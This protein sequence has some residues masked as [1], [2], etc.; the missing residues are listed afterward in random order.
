MICHQW[1][2]AI[3]SVYG[4]GNRLLIA[5]LVIG[6]GLVYG[7]RPDA[8]E[9]QPQLGAT[10]LGTHSDGGGE[11]CFKVT[12]D[13]AAARGF[14]L[15][16]GAEVRM[17]ADCNFRVPSDW[18]ILT[19]SEIDFIIDLGRPVERCRRSQTTYQGA[20]VA[21][22]T[23]CTV[24]IREQSLG[25]RNDRLGFS[26]AGTFFGEGCSSG[27][28]ETASLPSIGWSAQAGSCNEAPPS[29]DEEGLP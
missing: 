29:S 3:K 20:L 18:L 13:G 28:F 16:W 7:T 10:Y 24:P 1:L 17:T 6:I 12:A 14:V 21:I 22:F 26:I 15:T 8:A 4:H 27:T 5:A 25:Y 9:A 19:S 11:V 23:N 2:T